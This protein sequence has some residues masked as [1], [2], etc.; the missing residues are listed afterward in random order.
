MRQILL[1][2]KFNEFFRFLNAELSY[3][4]RVQMCSE[5]LAM[6]MGILKM[7]RP[8]TIV[9]SA[10]ELDESHR[11]LFAYIG[12]QCKGIPVWCIGNRDELER[13]R[14]FE[15]SEDIG[16]IQRPVRMSEII[17]AI[18][19]GTG[20]TEEV[21]L[22]DGREEICEKRTILLVDDAAVQLRAMKNILRENYNV[23]MATSAKM[24][25]E[26]LKKRQMDL[27]LLDY[28]MPEHDGRETFEMIRKEEEGKDVPVVF[29]TGVNDKERII[30]VLKMKPAGYLVKPVQTEELLET[31][32]QVLKRE[33]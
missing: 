12:R 9:I 14:E 16:M 26:I 1:V 30:E 27:I 10:A 19:G 20:I 8:D 24:A 17:A 21:Q 2:G 25:M 23:E 3:R 6:M 15:Q 4:F 22:H 33:V 29:V 31:V 5:D 28:D 11:E 7:S 32:K 18:H 13:I